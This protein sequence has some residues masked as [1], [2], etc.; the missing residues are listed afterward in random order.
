MPS[1]SIENLRIA[2]VVA[3]AFDTL[4]IVLL[5]AVALL[6]VAGPGIYEPLG[7]RLKRRTANNPVTIAL[8]LALARVW[9]CPSVG[10]L[11]F[12]KPSDWLHAAHGAALRFHRR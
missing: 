2:R 8:A 6:I 9:T 3:L 12:G 4:L 10:F 5:A 11:C 1:A 7:F